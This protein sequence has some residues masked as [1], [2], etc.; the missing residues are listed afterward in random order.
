MAEEG[1][2]QSGASQAQGN[3][4]AAAQGTQ[5]QAAQ[6]AAPADAGTVLTGDGAAS[7]QAADPGTSQSW[8]DTLGDEYKSHEALK[9][10]ADANALAKSYLELKQSHEELS[11]K[12]PKVPENA[13]GYTLEIPQGLPVDDAFVSTMKEA[14]HKAGM[15]Q[16]QFESMAKEYMTM[17]QAVSAHM[18]KE[19]E[20]SM[21]A[22]KIE[23]G[24]GYDAKVEQARMAFRK[25]ASEDDI[26][27]FNQSGFGND[28][29]VI[30]LFQK[31]NAAVSE[32]N[33]NTGGD[34][35]VHGGSGRIKPML[36]FPSMQK[37]RK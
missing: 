33:G 16:E 32:D 15:G 6:S 11:T 20:A 8:L 25:F 36:D 4:D 21:N 1:M 5:S 28:P 24:T 9:D 17:Q 13:Q 22:L 37:G 29:A 26:K 30:R 3:S 23:W 2:A 27:H 7:Q 18:Q 34:G 14:A 19:A 10:M 12:I 31:V 35:G